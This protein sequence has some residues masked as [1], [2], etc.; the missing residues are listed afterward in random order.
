[1]AKSHKHQISYHL[2]SMPLWERSNWCKSFKNLK[3]RV[4]QA[5]W[6]MINFTSQLTMTTSNVEQEMRLTWRPP[7]LTKTRSL[8][9]Q[10]KEMF[11]KIFCSYKQPIIFWA[12]IFPLFVLGL[13]K[14]LRKSKIRSKMLWVESKTFW[15]VILMVA[16]FK[17]NKYFKQCS[18]KRS[19]ISTQL[20]SPTSECG[21]NSCVSFT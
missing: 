9:S 17:M 3:L 6:L 16:C 4:N 14:F 11:S 19:M 13:L 5:R 1:M 21:K 8:L 7:D 10:K 20:S 2:L 15:R 18:R 12:N